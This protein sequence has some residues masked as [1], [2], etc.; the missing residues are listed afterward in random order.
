MA[1]ATS[2]ARKLFSAF[3]ALGLSAPQVRALM[4]DWWD[5]EAATDEGGLLEL[6]ILLARRLNV[7]LVSLQS[8][9]PQPAFRSTTQRFKTVHPEGST[10][11]AVA[12]SIGHGLAQLLASSCASTPLRP[13]V[14]ADTL[15]QELLKSG[16]A[17]TL[18]ALCEWLWNAGIPVVHVTGWPNGL[19]RP[20]AMCV[21]A[22]GRPVVMVVRKE[23]AL[24]KLAYLVSHEAGH[25]MSGHLS[26]DENAVLVD[27]TLP[28][29]NQRSFFD[30]DEKQADAYAMNLLGG[31]TLVAS[32]KKLVGPAYSEMSL[33]AAALG[34]AQK[35]ELDAGQVILS[36]ARLTEDWK[37]ANLALRFLKTTEIAPIVIND[38]AK[39]HMHHEML[40]NDGLD[41]I[42]KLTGMDLRGV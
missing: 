28:V 32:S 27:D 24:A 39:R 29:D 37:L 14:E 22:S 3:K 20:D 25:V 10:Q 16:K 17:V 18:D 23:T 19:R 42:F 41:H 33:A 38:V 2:P 4:P 36:W 1:T 13:P 34:E 6:Q 11:L 40:P 9:Q 12:A 8:Q 5:D 15:R 30:Q 21:R 7:S 35:A 31:S 26:S